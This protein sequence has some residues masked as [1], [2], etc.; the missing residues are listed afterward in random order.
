MAG[1]LGRAIV[2]GGSISGILAARVLS[3]S[4]E[5][6]TIFDRDVLPTDAVNRRGAPHG[7]HTHAL[8]ARGRQVLEELFPGF[9][10]DAPAGQCP[11]PV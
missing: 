1:K 8:L 4:Y 2:L 3:E 7:A 9:T 11:P 6:V 10:A 5:R